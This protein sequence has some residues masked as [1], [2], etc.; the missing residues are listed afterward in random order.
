MAVFAPMPS[1]KVSTAT[2]VKPG[3][4]KSWRKAKR[5]SFIDLRSFITQ[6]LHRIDFCCSTGGEV[7]CE[8]CHDTNNDRHYAEGQR[9]SRFDIEKEAPQKTRE[10][11]GSEESDPHADDNQAHPLAYHHIEDIQSLG[12]EGH[13]EADLSPPLGH[14]EGQNAVETDDSQN[15][16]EPSERAQK[17]EI[18]SFRRNIL[19]AHFF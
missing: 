19:V 14:R 3:F 2:A 18:Q 17:T 11:N 5:R 4:F 9:V 1:A 13:S 15:Q 6:R 10:S 16:S 7:A 8:Q 12:T